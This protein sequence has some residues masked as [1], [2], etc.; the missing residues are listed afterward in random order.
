MRAALPELPNVFIED[1]SHWPQLDHPA[2]VASIVRR[3]LA[4]VDR[5]RS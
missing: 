2:E 3:F 1:S 5:R 4:D